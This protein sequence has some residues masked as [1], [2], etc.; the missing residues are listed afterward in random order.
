MDKEE[1]EEGKSKPKRCQIH[2]QCEQCEKSYAVKRDLQDHIVFT[3]QGIRKYECQECKKCFELSKSYRIHLLSHTDLIF[4]CETCGHNSKSKQKYENH[5]RKHT[6][7]KPYACDQC[8]SMFA[9]LSTLI[10]HRKLHSGEAK[11]ICTLCGKQ[12]SNKKNLKRHTE[13]M[14][15]GRVKPVKPCDESKLKCQLCDGG[16]S[17]LANLNRHMK[18]KHSPNF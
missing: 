5:K 9:D 12:I 2:H 11:V 14:H 7:E 18:Q 1:Q 15:S 4:Q 8:P 17:K 16:F 13:K 10:A 3:H 6:G